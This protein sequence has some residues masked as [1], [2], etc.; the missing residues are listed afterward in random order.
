VRL[1]EE[2]FKRPLPMPTISF[3]LV[4]TT[5]GRAFSKEWH[6]QLSSVL[7]TENT[8]QFEKDT[9]PHEL[10][11]LIAYRMH[12]YKVGH[13]EHWKNIMLKLGLQ[14]N[15]LHQM[16]VTNART[17]ESVGGYFCHCREHELTKRMHNRFV[18]GTLIRCSRCKQRLTRNLAMV[19][20]G[21]MEPVGA[22]EVPV[23]TNRAPGR[24]PDPL[25][26]PAG[27]RSPS[28]AMLQFAESLAKKHHISLPPAVVAQF[29]A[30]K[31]FLDTWGNAAVATNVSQGGGAA[32]DTKVP[33]SVSATSITS[34]AAGASGS[35][36][37]PTPAQ[38]N[39]AKSIASR[40]NL[41]IDVEAMGSKRAMSAWIDANK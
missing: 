25:A 31:A 40:K 13:G 3:D 12:G 17:T 27:G 37:G 38:L 39:Y 7:L 14:P 6:I 22:T 21:V 9:I 26:P 11:H 2:K 41:I 32:S 18:A 19:R 24:I 1:A 5:A 23:V 29:E 28:P 10:A 4:G 8:E 33:T 15:R 35:P 36:D 20:G 30:C 16:D 34:P